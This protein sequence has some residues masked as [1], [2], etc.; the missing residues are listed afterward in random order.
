MRPQAG[1]QT[2]DKV[3]LLAG[4]SPGC[5]EAE[6]HLPKTLVLA[7]TQHI[8]WSMNMLNFKFE[9]FMV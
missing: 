4:M 9:I 1:S 3:L 8:K 6:S 2:S 7:V 5:K